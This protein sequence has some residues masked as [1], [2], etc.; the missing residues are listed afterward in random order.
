MLQG[1]G[2]LLRAY[3]KHGQGWPSFDT[4]SCDCCGWLGCLTAQHAQCKEGVRV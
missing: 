3:S 2:I 4:V 1:S